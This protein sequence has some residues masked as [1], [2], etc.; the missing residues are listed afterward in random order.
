[1]AHPPPGTGAEGSTLVLAEGCCPTRVCRTVPQF[2]GMPVD[3]FFELHGLEAK[4]DYRMDLDLGALEGSLTVSVSCSPARECADVVGPPPQG[5]TSATVYASFREMERAVQFQQQITLEMEV[6]EEKEAFVWGHTAGKVH[7]AV[8]AYRP[9][10]HIRVRA[11]VGAPVERRKDCLQP[12]KI[13]GLHASGARDT[14]ELKQWFW[15]RHSALTFGGETALDEDGRTPLHHSAA[16]L[17][18][19]RIVSLMLRD[20]RRFVPVD[21]RDGSGRTAL[22]L[23]AMHGGVQPQTPACRRL[24]HLVGLL[25]G[26]GGADGS[27]ADDDGFTPLH[28]AACRFCGVDELIRHL[29]AAGTQL[30]QA[31]NNA[32]RTA[33]EEAAESKWKLPPEM[34]RRVRELLTEL[35]EHGPKGHDPDQCGKAA[36]ELVAE[37]SYSAVPAG[38]QPAAWTPMVRSSVPPKERLRSKDA[39]LPPSLV[40]RDPG[41]MP[42]GVIDEEKMRQEFDKYDLN[43]NGYLTL[44]ELKLLYRDYESYGVRESDA[45]VEQLVRGC[46]MLDDGRVTYEEFCLLLLRI[47]AR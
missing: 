13:A 6:G 25:L 27:A 32:G 22:H 23:L 1:M 37:M 4:V 5:E 17:G 16:G 42:V 10:D 11:T 45:E 7:L 20:Y 19:P 3:C 24:L 46:G 8:Y 41:G 47:E 44:N 33:E 2:Q 21:A 18:D 29:G 12:W 35:R 30:T 43:G 40:S 14:E 9:L 36:A 38:R 34:L 39:P 15:E 26:D 28:H 31:R